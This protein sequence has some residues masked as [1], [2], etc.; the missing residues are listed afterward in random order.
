MSASDTSVRVAS[1]AALDR[2]LTRAI[3]MEPSRADRIRQDLELL[4]RIASR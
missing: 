2:W 1:I 4:R 3:T